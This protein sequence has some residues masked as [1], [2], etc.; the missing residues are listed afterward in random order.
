VGG[1]ALCR[2]EGAVHRY[3]SLAWFS[4]AI[5]VISVRVRAHTGDPATQAAALEAVQ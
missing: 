4:S 5:S 2:E 1:A 3:Q